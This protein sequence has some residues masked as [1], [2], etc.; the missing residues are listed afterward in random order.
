MNAKEI[1]D[2]SGLCIH[3]ITTKP[4]ALPEAVEKYAAAGVKGISV[5][6]NATEGIGPR[7]AG[8]IIRENLVANRQ[9]VRVWRRHPP[10]LIV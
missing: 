1:T 7:R 9:A 4:W 10:R 2:L 8:E 6:Q 3:T 5:W